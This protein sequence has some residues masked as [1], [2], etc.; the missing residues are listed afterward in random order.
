VVATRV[1]GTVELIQDG[2]SGRLV[3]PGE[4]EQFADAILAS[5][6][7]PESARAM[8]IQARAFTI[9]HFDIRTVTRQHEALYR[10][11]MSIS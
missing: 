9:Q 7:R 3:T 8:A 2:V 4:P 1:S 11:L 6:A 10:Q 5:L